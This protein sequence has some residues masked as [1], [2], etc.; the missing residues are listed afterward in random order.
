M[1][2]WTLLCYGERFKKYNL[3]LESLTIFFR[4]IIILLLFWY[5]QRDSYN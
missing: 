5:N 4:K 1:Y 3:T 2:Q